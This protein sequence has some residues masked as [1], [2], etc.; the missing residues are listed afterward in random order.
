MIERIGIN[1]TKLAISRPVS[2]EV[3]ASLI[4]ASGDLDTRECGGGRING[5]VS[6]EGDRG[7]SSIRGIRGEFPHDGG[8]EGVGDKEG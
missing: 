5:W 4:Y 7:V 6:S 8:A 1:E 2:K 3:I